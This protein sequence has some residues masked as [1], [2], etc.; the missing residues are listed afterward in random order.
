M[1]G[2]GN[3]MVRPGFTEE[4]RRDLY[5]RLTAIVGPL[6]TTNI[7]G[8]P[9]FGVTKLNDTSIRVAFEQML[10]DIAAMGSIV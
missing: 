2:L 8:Y 7:N 5:D 6:S 9:S 3:L 4:A 1:L 10:H